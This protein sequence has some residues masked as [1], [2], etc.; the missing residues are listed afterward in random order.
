ML[1]DLSPN[2][3]SSIFQQNK[4]SSMHNIHFLSDVI[5][6][7]A[8]GKFETSNNRLIVIDRVGRHFIFA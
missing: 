7:M 3:V 4:M 8:T 2:R 6:D 5:D 1:E